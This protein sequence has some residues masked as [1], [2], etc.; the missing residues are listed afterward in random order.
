MESP[1]MVTMVVMVM[2]MMGDWRCRV[3]IVCS[4]KWSVLLP[5]MMMAIRLS[6]ALPS[7]E[8]KERG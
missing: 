5:V 6:V 8:K 4:S 1:V 7:K 3:C 2:M